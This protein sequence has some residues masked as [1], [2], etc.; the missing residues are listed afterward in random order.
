MGALIAPCQPRC[1]FA[2]DA[3]VPFL[4]SDSRQTLQVNTEER[5][6]VAAK[7]MSTLRKNERDIGTLLDVRIT[8][9]IPRL[10]SKRDT[11]TA[12]G[13]KNQG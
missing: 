8:E 6:D 5:K 9:E 4:N 7:K 3:G 12:T 1:L 13:Q 10:E 2:A 11:G